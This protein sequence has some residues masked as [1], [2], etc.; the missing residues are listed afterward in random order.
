MF[1]RQLAAFVRFDFVAVVL[2]ETHLL[3][4]AR[5][6]SLL[7]ARKLDARLEAVL[8]RVTHTTLAMVSNGGSTTGMRRLMRVPGVNLRSV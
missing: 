6:V 4:H 1:G 8:A 2:D 3:A 5:G 7:G